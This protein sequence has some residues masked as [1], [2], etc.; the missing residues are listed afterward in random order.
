M[1]PMKT[2]K[3]KHETAARICFPQEMG[4]ANRKD[5]SVKARKEVWKW[6]RSR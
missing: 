6:K 2:M 3:H 1:K 5:M 4:Q